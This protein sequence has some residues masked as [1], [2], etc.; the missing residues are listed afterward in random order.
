M[1]PII[2]STEMVKAILD[3][4]KTQTRRIIKPQP[5][6]GVADFYHRPDG[7]F[8]GTHLKVGVGC[9]VGNPICCPYGKPGDKLWVR[10]T[11][12]GD[13]WCGYFYKADGTEL[14]LDMG[15]VEFKR[16]KPSI[17]MPRDAARI[18]L[19]VVSVRVERLRDISTEDIHQEG[20]ELNLEPG[21]IHEIPS[22]GLAQQWFKDLWD[23]INTKRGYP[24]ESNPWVW[25]VEFE[26][27]E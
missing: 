19:Q 11:F 21:K 26:V 27:E 10:E 17:H 14:P 7:L 6:C 15:E 13:G 25:V 12:T 22:M 8:Q 16:W 24:W 2:F 18:T 4:R 20:F 23:N 3:G 9:G 5:G 1:K